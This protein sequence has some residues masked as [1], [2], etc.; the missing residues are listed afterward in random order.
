MTK[1]LIGLNADFD[2][3]GDRPFH[4]LFA[5]YTA[6]A[7][8]A[9]GLPILLPTFACKDEA[10]FALE[11]LDA[12]ILTGGRDVDPASY[13]RGKHPKT[14]IVPA[15]RAR[16]DILL[17]R[18]ALQ[19]R[20]PLLGI[21]MGC[22]LL[23]VAAGGTLI[24][25]IPS[26]L[27]DALDHSRHD[28]GAGVVHGVDVTGGTRLHSIVGTLN[29]DVN[30][31]HHQGID[32]VGEGLVVSARSGDG[33]IE[34]VEAPDRWII[35]VQWHPERLIARGEHLALFEALVNEALG[36]RGGHR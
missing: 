21:C 12:L 35:G 14:I 19:R 29:L 11:G 22:Q 3:G 30:S 25:D 23:N 34:A 36:P 17:A 13:G 5:E 32:R 7:R 24:Q 8:A 15:E 9:G 31:T 4:K 27:P 33:V 10:V 26:R 16:S 18:A 28:E 20:R 1:A 2:K 6:A